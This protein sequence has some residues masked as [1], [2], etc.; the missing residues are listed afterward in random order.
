[1]SARTLLFIIQN[2]DQQHRFNAEIN[3]DLSELIFSKILHSMTSNTQSSV[4]SPLLPPSLFFLH[5]KN[6]PNSVQYS[7]FHRWNLSLFNLQQ[8]NAQMFCISELLCRGCPEMCSPE[9]FFDSSPKDSF[10]NSG[11]PDLLLQQQL[12]TDRNTIERIH[13]LSSI[14]IFTFG[15]SNGW[16]ETMEFA[17]LSSRCCLYS[18]KRFQWF[19]SSRL[20]IPLYRLSIDISVM[21]VINNDGT[22]AENH[23]HITCNYCC[24][25]YYYYCFYYNRKYIMSWEF[26]LRWNIYLFPMWNVSG[27]S[28]GKYCVGDCEILNLTPIAN[29]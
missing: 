17:L 19:P 16:R 26:S 24:Y 4:V 8:K 27:I 20:D 15:F 21:I 10:I 28:L 6:Q 13:Y 2:Q 5:I 11:I 29:I 12:P 3:F 18:K 7:Q 9:R 23:F 14:F 1:M 25:H 22:Y